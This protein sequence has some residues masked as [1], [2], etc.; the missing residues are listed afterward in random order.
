MNFFDPHQGHLLAITVRS[1]GWLLREFPSARIDVSCFPRHSMIAAVRK[2]LPQRKEN[3]FHDVELPYSLSSAKNFIS[4]R[5]FNW[6]SRK[7]FRSIDFLQSSFVAIVLILT[8]Y[9][10]CHF[11]FFYK[12][13]DVISSDFFTTVFVRDGC[14]ETA[15]IKRT[16]GS[17]ILCSLHTPRQPLAVFNQFFIVFSSEKSLYW[18]RG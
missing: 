10:F 12:F 15:N 16:N 3:L 5:F 8:L 4:Y 14:G 13:S 11:V 9:A 7:G 17:T 1:R 6:N 2:H 18:V